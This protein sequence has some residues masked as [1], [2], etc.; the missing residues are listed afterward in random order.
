MTIRY[1]CPECGAALNINDELAGT[2]G[3]CP[4]CQS[5]FVVPAPE[6]E[7]VPKAEAVPR[8]AAEVERP[9]R[10]RAAGAGA[11][12]SEDDIGDF[13]NSEPSPSS[14]GGQIPSLDSDDELPTEQTNP[15]DQD[16]EESDSDKRSRKQKSKRGGSAAAKSDST[17]S[18]SIAK[19]L[20]GK[21]ATSAE[22]PEPDQAGK[23][24]RK[25]FGGSEERRPGELTG[26]KDVVTYFAK[27]G[28]PFVAGAG[29]FL[30]LCV[31]LSFSM[32]KHFE[33]P[34]LARVTGTVTLD[35]K[36]LKDAIVKFVPQTT[37]EN[38]SLGTSFGMTDASGKYD[39]SYANDDGTPI[40]GAVI[41][42]HQVQIQ[43]NDIGGEQKIP[44]RYST[45]D[46][47]L[48]ADVKKGMLPLDFE[49]KS[50]PV[51]KTE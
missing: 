28:W 50:D 3:N 20:M 30:G 29:A 34:P 27:M 23:K 2:E 11:P 1:K 35:G 33:A 18:A 45:F 42:K 9:A 44:G 10:G 49:L 25:Q 32:M 51:E 36:P 37:K 13:L 22:A 12:L 8:S 21:G 6:A 24:K 5:Q 41:G 38:Y 43:L 15:F 39:L 16:R 17:E 47:E 4:R 19:S 31:Y 40:M 46:S 48:K 7:A 14:S 26:I